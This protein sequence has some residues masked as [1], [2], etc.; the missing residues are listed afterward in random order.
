MTLEEILEKLKF[1]EI[2]LDELTVE[3]KQLLANNNIYLYDGGYENIGVI[4]GKN[5]ICKMC[6]EKKFCLTIDSSEGEY[7][8]GAI[9]KDC[10]EDV[11]K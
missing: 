8:E 5:S 1:R 9:C 10:I 7:I 3:Q 2:L 11:F 4:R 6:E